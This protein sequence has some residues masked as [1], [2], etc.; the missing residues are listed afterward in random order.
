[1]KLKAIKYLKQADIGG[2]ANI[3][4]NDEYYMCYDR[5]LKSNHISK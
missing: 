2:F 4:N 3:I 5:L 1:M